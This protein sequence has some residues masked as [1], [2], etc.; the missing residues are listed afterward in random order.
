VLELQEKLVIATQ[1]GNWKKVY[2][3][4][5]Q[6]RSRFQINL[7]NSFAARALAVRNVVT[8]KG[9]KTPG[10]DNIL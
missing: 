6:R 5:R 2:I 9:A 3:A 10:V 8:N 4:N 7:L 1:A